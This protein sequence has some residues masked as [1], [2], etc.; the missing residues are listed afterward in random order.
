LDITP[1][2]QAAKA[3]IDKWDYIKLKSFHTAKKPST[4]PR[5]NLQNG[6]RYQQ[7]THLTG[8][9]VNIQSL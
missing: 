4:E 2:V 9:E 8:Q 7:I 6:K 1:Q 5:D 3:E